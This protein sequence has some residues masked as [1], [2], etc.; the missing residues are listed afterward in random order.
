MLEMVSEFGRRRRGVFGLAVSVMVA[1]AVVLSPVAEAAKKGRAVS[2]AEANGTFQTADGLKSMKI[3]ALGLGGPDNPGYGLQLEFQ[4]RAKRAQE[5]FVFGGYGNIAADVGR[6]TPEGKNYDGC[7]IGL[8]FVRSG[9]VTVTQK[10]SCDLLGRTVAGSYKKSKP[11][12]PTFSDLSEPQS[13]SL[14]A[15]FAGGFGSNTYSNLLVRAQTITYKVEVKAKQVLSVRLSDTARVNFSVFGPDG[16][17]EPDSGGITEMGGL[18][19]VPGV[20]SL[21]VAL[22]PEQKFGLK[23]IPFDITIEV[24]NQV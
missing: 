4:V 18:V 10:G 24:A 22:N 17:L 7:T 8:K 2:E 15:T 5:P 6:F 23:P 11:G 14:W 16:Q 20:Y 12:V 19:D 13:E 21:L 1:V 9:T 3:Q